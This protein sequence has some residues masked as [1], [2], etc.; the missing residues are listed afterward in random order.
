MRLLGLDE[1]PFRLG[2][3][4]NQGCTKNLCDVQ[5]FARTGVGLRLGPVQ[6]DPTPPRIWRLHREPL[7]KAASMP[8]PGQIHPSRTSPVNVRSWPNPAV[9]GWRRQCRLV[10]GS[11]RPP[12]YRRGLLP[13]TLLT[14]GGL[15][16]SGRSRP[17]AGVTPPTAADSAHRPSCPI[18]VRAHWYTHPEHTIRH[19]TTPIRGSKR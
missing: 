1:P 17:I 12:Q 9:P 3:P 7:G 15:A 11:R 18:V 13:V 16:S 8:G 14:L 5:R 10:A 6:V 19:R 4:S 2:R